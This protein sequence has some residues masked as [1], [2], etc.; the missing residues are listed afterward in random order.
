MVRKRLPGYQHQLGD[1]AVSQELDE[2]LW[3]PSSSDGLEMAEV[4]TIPE[5]ADPSA[6]S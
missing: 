2:K 4:S 3:D 6:E 1:R 5:L